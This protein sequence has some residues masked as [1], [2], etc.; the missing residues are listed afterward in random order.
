MRFAVISDIHSNFPALLAVEKEL[1]KLA[2]DFVI[3]AGDFLNR[4]P[5][6]R[7]VLEFLLEKNW[8]LLRGN[9]EDYV[10]AQ[11][12]GLASGFA[13]DD[14]RGNSIWQPARWT[15]EAIARDDSAFKN[16]PL[17]T[18]F[19]APHGH[20]SHVNRVLDCDVLVAHGTPQVNN[21]GVFRKTS[22]EQLRQ[23]LGEQ[24]PSLFVCAHT[25]VS[26][27]RKIDATLVVNVGSVGLPFNGDV[28]A[29]FGVFTRRNNGWNA[30]LC[31]VNYDRAATLRA[32]ESGGFLEHGGPLARV[33]LHEVE[34]ARPHLGPWVRQF[35]EVVKGEKLSVAQATDAYFAAL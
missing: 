4:G 28:R 17:T 21:N 25:H 20:V 19:Q 16:L 2:P 23:M 30:Q 26:L 15:A 35:S 7:E 24:A 13:P 27:I 11:C 18:A 34:T 12:E 31:K 10:I 22:D 9:H 14:I 33:I 1:K 29:Q 5:Q 3:V 32:F 8:P 6:P